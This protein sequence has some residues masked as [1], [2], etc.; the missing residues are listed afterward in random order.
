MCKY[1]ISKDETE[2]ESVARS[3]LSCQAHKFCM[4]R[5]AAF[6]LSC[7]S[8]IMIHSYMEDVAAGGLSS[9][10]NTSSVLCSVR[11]NK[12]P[13]KVLIF[14]QQIQPL[15]PKNLSLLVLHTEY[16]FLYRM[17][18]FTCLWLY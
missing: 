18:N 7:L 15:Q 14:L 5:L 16:K 1:I 9:F 6:S 2:E 17:S 4:K 3:R 12:F 10:K 8:C 11:E 13:G